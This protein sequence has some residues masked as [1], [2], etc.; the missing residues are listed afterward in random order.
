ME[1]TTIHTTETK[2]TEK[3]RNPALTAVTILGFIILLFIGI[4]L[5]IYSAR[6]VSDAV[7]KL[8]SASAYLSHPGG[9]E[10]P[11]QL[12][13]VSS[14]TVPF[15]YNAT[16]TVTTPYSVTIPQ[17]TNIQT[18]SPPATYPTRTNY[19]SNYPPSYPSNNGGRGTRAPYGLPDLATTIISVGYLANASNDSFV[20]APVIPVGA[21]AAVRFTISN[22]GT[23]ASGPWNFGARIPT[24][25]GYTYNSP[26]EASLNPGDG[27]IFTLGF[28][29]VPPG[30]N[31][32]INILVDP[33]NLIQETN[34]ANNNAVGV[35]SVV[36]S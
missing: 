36:A 35:V 4:A 32:P 7:S 23:N 9:S 14:T 26:I 31:E 5:A 19:P 16:S 17:A 8:S 20:A 10:Y 6:Y 25:N 3:P 28:D 34:E 18:Y 12:A 22:A 15:G 11:A 13:V 24:Q 1:S 29:Q 33:N 21:R 27:V 30:S 2:K